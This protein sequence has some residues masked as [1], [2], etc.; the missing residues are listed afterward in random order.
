MYPSHE[1]VTGLRF[2]LEASFEHLLVCVITVGS[3]PS[4]IL[5]AE[6]ILV[7]VKLRIITGARN[8]DMNDMMLNPQ[9]AKC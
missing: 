3:L 6:M 4:H 5:S 7:F 2:S 1:S 8:C 9:A